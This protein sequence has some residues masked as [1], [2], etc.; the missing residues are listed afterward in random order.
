MPS[1]AGT[2]LYPL[3]DQQNTTRD[4]VNSTGAVQNHLTYNNFGKITAE[5]NAAVDYLFG[6]TGMER[7]EKLGVDR[8][9][10]RYYFAD[11]N[12]HEELTH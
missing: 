11:V 2:V 8:A 4:L 9:D 10:H 5:T 7:D 1:S 12:T 6:Y 3:T